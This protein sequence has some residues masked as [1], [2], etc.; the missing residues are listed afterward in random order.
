M[1]AALHETRRS[2][3][4]G[5]S[6]I[7]PRN[8]YS[9]IRPAGPAR[10]GRAE[11]QDCSGKGKEGA[12]GEIRETGGKKRAAARDGRQAGRKECAG[13]TCPAIEARTERTARRWRQTHS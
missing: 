2:Y 1:E 5:S 4:H 6:L 10:A 12:A 8:W 3:Q 11:R 13:T 7:D 9:G